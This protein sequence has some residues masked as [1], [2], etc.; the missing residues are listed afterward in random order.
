MHSMVADMTMRPQIDSKPILPA[1]CLI[2]RLDRSRY[3][4]GSKSTTAYILGPDP[5]R[6][7]VQEILVRNAGGKWD[8]QH[9]DSFVLHLPED[10]VLPRLGPIQETGLILKDLTNTL[11]RINREDVLKEAQGESLVDL[12]KSLVEAARIASSRLFFDQ[13]TTSTPPPPPSINPPTIWCDNTVAVGLCNDTLKIARTKS[14]DLRFHWLRDRIRQEQFNVQWVKSEDN[15]ADFFTKALPVHQHI[16]RRNQ[17]VIGPT[18]NKR[19]QRALSWR[20]TTKYHHSI[21]D[22]HS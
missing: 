13:P 3:K 17:L 15:I 14:I 9:E 1:A 5:K 21:I 7:H 8:V 18:L 11:Q 22:S 16:Q 20:T 19:A 4:D 2:S 6:H 10:V 12:G